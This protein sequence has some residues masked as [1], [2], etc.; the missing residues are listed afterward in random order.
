MRDI[1]VNQELPDVQA[2]FRKG[3]GARDQI[4][5]IHWIIEKAREFQENIYFCFID[6]TKA[7]DF[8]D[9]NKLQKILQEVGIPDY[10]ICLPRNLYAGQEATV[11]TRRTRNQIANIRWIIEKAREF[12]KNI[13]FC[14][15]DY[16][17]ALDCVD[18]NKLENSERDGNT[19][20]PD[21]PLE[22]SV[23]RSGSNS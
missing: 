6:Y 21:L 15:I 3:R 10:V 14:F 2:G 23:C 1:Y 16:A 13:Y 18:H 5:N 12:Q 4:A 22:K 7:F 20:S 19:R 8:V 17:K 9:H 11:R